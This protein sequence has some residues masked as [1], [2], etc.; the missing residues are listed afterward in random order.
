MSHILYYS[1]HCENSKKCIHH[2][3]K[4]NLDDIHYLCID[5]RIQKNNA[6]YLIIEDKHEVLLPPTV[7]KVPAL[8][9]LNKGHHVIYGSDIYKYFE[10]KLN[11]LQQTATTIHEEPV[12]YSLNQM[13]NV[14]DQ[15]SFL[16]QSIDEL[17]TKGNGGLRQMHNYVPIS[18]VD[19]IETPPDNYKA[20]TIGNV[21]VDSMVQNRNQSI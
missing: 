19:N 20:D 11:S 5:K 16:D 12:C 9:L 18:S 1:N 3:G 14:S 13:N 7:T 8:L 21:S 10:P 4:F 15:Y 6:T 17:S 2:L